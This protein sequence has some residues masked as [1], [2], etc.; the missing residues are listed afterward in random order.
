MSHKTKII[1]KLTWTYRYKKICI[2]AFNSYL[3]HGLRYFSL[4]F[5]IVLLLWRRQTA[6]LPIYKRQSLINIYNYVYIFVWVHVSSNFL[7][8]THQI[9]VLK[10]IMTNCLLYNLLHENIIHTTIHWVIILLIFTCNNNT[11]YPRT[12]FLL[13]I[14]QKNT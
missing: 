1:L 6:I 13:T 9:A 10:V 5:V 2:L 7:S 14:P 3:F 11:C 8:T 12:S 4:R